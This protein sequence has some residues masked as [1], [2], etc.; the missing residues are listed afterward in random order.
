M[1]NPL[2]D[3]SFE[4][5]AEEKP[6]RREPARREPERAPA[7][8]GNPLFDYKFEEAG[9]PK[10]QYK[11]MGYGE[12]A[13]RALKAF[14]ESAVTTAKSMIEPFYPENI[15]QTAVNLGSLG[16]AQRLKRLALWAMK[17]SRP[18][19]QATKPSSMQ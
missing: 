10:D 19:R 17:K 3:Y 8:S 5:T 11:T 16:M 1:A 12:V 15:P 6:A 18:R 14:P 13:G 9:Y 2:L 4:E 7:A